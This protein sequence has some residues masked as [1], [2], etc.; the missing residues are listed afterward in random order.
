M[1]ALAAYNSDSG[2]LLMLS[3]VLL[4]LLPLM[5]LSELQRDPDL[6][7]GLGEPG[8]IIE[9]EQIETNPGRLFQFSVIE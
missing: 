7:V 5:L 2:G 9:L 1:V 3:V 6:T 4:P 8:S